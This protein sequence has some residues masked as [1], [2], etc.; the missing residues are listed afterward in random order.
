MDLSQTFPVNTQITNYVF[1]G[2]AGCGKS[3]IA[4][5]LALWLR[6]LGK[7]VHLFDLDMTKPLFRTRDLAL[8]LENEGVNIHF[9]EQFA[10]APTTAGGVRRALAEPYCTILD[11]G[12]DYIGARA[13][14]AYAP[15]LRRADTAVYYVINPF[16]PW[17]TTLERLDGVFGQILQASH[18]SPDGLHLLGNPNL[19]PSTTAQD[20]ME[21]AASMVEMLSPYKP[22]EFMTVEERLIPALEG[23]VALPIFPLQRRLP[24]PWE[25]EK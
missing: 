14:G 13:V 18:L 22:V 21:G 11:V 1:L 5:N 19:G 3:E 24:Y 12:G 23:S 16:R 2:E 20:V 8:Q 6:G 4:V 17:S 25:K 7:E 9:Q 15:L 10:D